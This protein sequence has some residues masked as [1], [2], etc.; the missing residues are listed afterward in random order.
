MPIF[1]SY[2]HVNKKFVDKLAVQLVAHR[3]HVWLDRWEIH[4]GDSLLSKVQQAITGASGLLVVLSK[5]SVR[6]A[7]FTKELNSGLIRELEEKRI[8]VLPVLVE[9]CEIPVFLREKMY[10]DFRTDFD[11]GLR[12]VL[13]AIA[14][15]TNE[16]QGRTETREYHTDWAIDWG[17]V[18]GLATFRITMVDHHKD[19]PYSVVGEVNV[20]CGPETT[21]WYEVQRKNGRDDIARRDVI[22]ALELA[23]R[24]RPEFDV[25]LDDQLEVIRVLE[26]HLGDAKLGAQMGVRRLGIDTGRPILFRMRDQIAN[27]E[28]S[29]REITRNDTATTPAARTKRTLRRH[30]AQPAPAVTSRKSPRPKKAKT[31]TRSA[32]TGAKKRSTK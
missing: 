31:G 20:L 25:F 8:V 17:S 30:R 11:G 3:V 27:V 7:W 1:I 18:H 21:S 9:D 4:V 28:R 23:V 14:R 22:T 6:S 24:D 19:A 15:V 2:S 12:T 13:E 32:T 5:A 26:F 10:A 16:W 29:M